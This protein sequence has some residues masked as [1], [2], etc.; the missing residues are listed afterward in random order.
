MNNN[1]Q[2]LTAILSGLQNITIQATKN[3]VAYLDGVY[4]LL[5]D[6]IGSQLGQD[7]NPNQSNNQVG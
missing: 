7:E 4:H 5:D 1:T 6:M 3:N 2:Y